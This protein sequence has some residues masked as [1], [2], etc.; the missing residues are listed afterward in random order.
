MDNL[1]V[2]FCFRPGQSVRWRGLPGA[3]TIHARRFVEGATAQ[4]YTALP[5]TRA[6]GGPRYEYL[7]HSGLALHQDF[8]ADEGDLTPIPEET[9]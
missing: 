1:R 4:G 2:A 8:W 5:Q 7:V 9:P 6:A 3:Y